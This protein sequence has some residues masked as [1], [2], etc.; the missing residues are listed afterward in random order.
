MSEGQLAEILL[1]IGALL[2]LTYLVGGLLVRIRI[3]AMLGALLVAML[4][5]YTPLGTRLLSPEIYPAFDFL[6]ELGVL[7]L[8]FF[9]GLQIDLDEMR[10]MGRDIV[11]CTVLNT[12]MPFLLGTA[13]MLMLGYGWVLALVIGVTCMPTAEAVVVPILDEF[14]MVRT[15]VG[16]FII[17]VGT[18]DDVIEVILIAFVSIWIAKATGIAS[19]SASSLSS[20][21]M[22]VVVF[23]ASVWLLS[24]W[25]IPWSARW[26][27]TQPRYL[28]M[29]SVIVLFGL[30]G[31]TEYS[32]LGMVIG[33]ITAGVLM[34]SIYNKLGI[35][36]DQV[37]RS[38]QSL[39]YG[40]LGL[41]FFFWIGLSVDLEAMMKTPGLAILLFLA[42]LIGKLTG[43][44]LMV[45]MGKLDLIE[46]WTIGIGLNARLT[47]EIIVA[48]LLLTAGLIDKHLFT[49]LVAAA[50]LSTIIVPIC[51]T[52][53]LHRWGDRLRT[54]VIK[55][56]EGAHAG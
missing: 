16:Q 25:L 37:T 9:I 5:H 19:I 10:A 28:M 40:F 34:R 27:P 47:T 38:I 7:F 36:G 24:R 15:R 3:P 46:G 4:A 18:L 14:Q 33:A 55:Q 54:P 21:L 56:G 6:A 49:A 50:S 45:P 42:A 52:L 44:L 13:V 1:E 39:S 51:L 32:Q 11:W 23:V 22:S 43:V 20:L 26:L 31:Y 12:M 35:V 8:L 48:Q 41:V 30:A 53:L 2:A 29:L 17:G